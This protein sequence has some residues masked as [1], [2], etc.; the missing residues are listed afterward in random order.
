[1]KATLEAKEIKRNSFKNRQQLR[2]QQSL[3][4]NHSKIKKAF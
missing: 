2:K 3:I 1:M 4:E